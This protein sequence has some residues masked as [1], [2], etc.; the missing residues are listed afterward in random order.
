MGDTVQII[1]NDVNANM[2]DI[3]DQ[4]LRTATSAA[5]S[6]AFITESGLNTI[7]ENLEG[8][9]YRGGEVRVLTGL[10]QAITD[11]NSL[12]RMNDAQGK[13]GDKFLARISL[14]QQFHQKLYVIRSKPLDRTTIIIG[15]S[16]LTAGG[17]KSGGELNIM[18]KTRIGSALAR[19]IDSIFGEEWARGVKLSDDLISNYDQWYKDL[20]KY[21]LKMP[22]DKEIGNNPILDRILGVASFHRDCE[23]IHYASQHKKSAGRRRSWRRKKQM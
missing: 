22:G 14:E 11:S 4:E 6:V 19:K 23:G 1:P 15:S 10:Y 12:R 13:Y 7:L 16:N 8:I 21:A 17:L 20:R 3:L 5:L 2:R 9:S 18:I